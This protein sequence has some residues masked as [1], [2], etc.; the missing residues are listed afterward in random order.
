MNKRTRICL[1]V[2]SLV[3]STIA[4]A[5]ENDE[6]MYAGGTIL[7]VAA[8]TTGHLSTSA[9]DALIFEGPGTRIEIPYASINSFEYTQNVTR[10]L[11]VLPA[12]ATGLLR[13]R[14]HRH[15]FRIE[16]QPES[17]PPQVVILEVSKHVPKVLQAVLETRAPQGCK[18]LPICGRQP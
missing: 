10:H 8:G 3:V 7:A 17:Q 18:A 16:F 6:A 9:R 12:I 15:F 13:H 4:L 11:G 14:Q 2:Y 5:V 1:L